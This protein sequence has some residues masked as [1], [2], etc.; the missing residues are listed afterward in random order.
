MTGPQ[1]LATHYDVYEIAY[2]AGGPRRV[3]DSAVVALVESGRV[4]MTP[5]SGELSVV[6]HRRRHFVE[7]AV[8]DAIGARGQRSIATVRWRLESD[9]RLYPLEQRLDRDGLLSMAGSRSAIR[10]RHWRLLTLTGEGRR[11]LR[12]LRSDPPPDGVAGGTSAMAV[13]LAG[14][15]QMADRAVHAALFEPPRPR[16]AR[17]SPP[18]RYAGL[19][20]PTSLGWVGGSGDGGGG[21]CGDGGGGGCGD[22]GGGC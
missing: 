20:S 2:L 19:Y 15:G 22:G 9:E 7:A 13:A 18:D 6:E 21:F 10:R 3:V 5:I 16:R 14:P 12:R 1:T 17:F 8:L 11:T 4:S